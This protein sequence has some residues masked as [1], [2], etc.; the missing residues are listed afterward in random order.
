[1]T[2]AWTDHPQRCQHMICMMQ[3]TMRQEV[4]P[5][6]CSHKV[7][8]YKAVL[9]LTQGNRTCITA[10]SRHM[11]ANWQPSGET[12]F[13]AENMTHP[14][15]IGLLVCFPMVQIPLNI[16]WII[17]R[18]SIIVGLC[19]CRILLRRLQP[20]VPFAMLQIALCSTLMPKQDFIQGATDTCMPLTLGED[21]CVID[22]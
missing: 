15:G 2:V 10:Y 3:C 14:S 22:E 5:S 12:Q 11:H 13:Q 19:K 9:E 1:M 20:T 8:T 7:R 17:T 21:T 6:L 4:M 16:A 18:A